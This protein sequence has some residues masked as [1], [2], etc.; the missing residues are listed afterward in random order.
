MDT[1]RRKQIDPV[2]SGEMPAVDPERLIGIEQKQQRVAEF[3]KAHDYDALLLT[4]PGNFSWFT[5]GGNSVQSG[6]REP[7]AALFI[8]PDARVVVTDSSNSARL[9]D[10]ELP[11]L[12]FQLKERAWYEP[13]HLLVQDLCR[14][15]K[16]AADV[17]TRGVEDVSLHLRGLRL[18]LSLV[19]CER[20]R[21]LGRDVSHA[22]EATA[23]S[24]LQGQTEAEIAGE[25]A[26]RLIK[27]R[28][29]PERLQVFADLQALRYPHWGYG[30]DRV[31]R[32]CVI[33]AM[34]SRHGLHAGAA[35]SI[36]F[37]KAPDDVTDAHH[38]ATL[39]QAAGMYFCRPDWELFEVWN[40][41]VRI[42][43]KYGEPDAW[44]E[45]DQAEVVGYQACEM[46]IVPK[47]EFRLAARMPVYW[48][49]SVG[50]AIIGDTML[51]GESDFELLTPMGDWPKL[52]IKIKGVA[53][54]RPAILRRD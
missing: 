42:Y 52:H 41:I 50:P 47:S 36:C 43:E 18:P 1:E 31:E 49:P 34:G 15:R 48:H 32:S 26:H 12:G 44:L 6:S 16:M 20:V 11:G 7:T 37:G 53:I 8:T 9:F 13:R 21:E 27:R 5:S 2:S 14:S 39:V 3:L 29:I 35:R 40:R 17:E 22:V 46:P 23:R 54:D 4:K 30:S 45:A 24:F 51:V 10:R 19:E 33:A 38:R 25:V 28:I